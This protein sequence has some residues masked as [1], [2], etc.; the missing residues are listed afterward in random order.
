MS[1][2]KSET[3]GTLNFE[4]RHLKADSARLLKVKREG[5][6]EPFMQGKISHREFAQQHERSRAERRKVSSN[7]NDTSI[8]RALLKGL[9]VI[10]AFILL[11][12]LSICIYV[13]ANIDWAFAGHSSV[14]L[15]AAIVGGVVG[16]IS[17]Y[18]LYLLFKV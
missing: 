1:A 13:F 16:L 2:S 7:L 3:T 18:L 4:E 14:T 9:I 15:A 5:S 11:V 8:T 17:L 6:T 10:F 12:I